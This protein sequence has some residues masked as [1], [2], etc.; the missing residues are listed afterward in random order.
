VAVGDG[1][2]LFFNSGSITDVR[3]GTTVDFGRG[4]EVHSG[5]GGVVRDVAID[6]V[7]ETAIVA[8]ALDPMGFLHDTSLQLTDVGVTGVA[9]RA[10]V[11]SSCAT[12]GG[13][14]GVASLAGAAVTAEGLSVTGAPLC[15]VQV[16]DGASLDVG[17]STL[18]GNAIGAC[19][20]I[21]GYDLA[22][23]VGTTRF[24]ENGR[25]VE[26]VGVWVPARG[27]AF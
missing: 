27:P 20:Q 26:T 11:T 3:A 18:A 9:E 24:E 4:I 22:R 21:D 5:G 13:G 7:V 15:G 8:F 1:S 16:V 6:G 23:I 14:T 17:R 25:N 19:V 12:E 2:R 10:C